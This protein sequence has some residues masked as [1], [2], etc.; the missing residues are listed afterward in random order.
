MPL[1]RPASRS[2]SGPATPFRALSLAQRDFIFLQV[3]Y[4]DIAAERRGFTE[5]ARAIIEQH[6]N[7]ANV[8][9]APDLL[10]PTQSRS[11]PPQ[12]VI[13]GLATGIY[14][15]MLL[16]DGIS[17]VQ[18]RFFEYQPPCD[19]GHPSWMD[20]HSSPALWRQTP[21][22]YARGQFH[23]VI[24]EQ[25]QRP[26]ATPPRDDVPRRLRHLSQ[27]KAE[28]VLDL[29]AYTTPRSAP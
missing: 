20:R 29:R 5:T 2:A 10:S 22:H 23:L 8:C 13:E 4:N 28:M 16:P 1:L 27:H 21:L 24:D 14:E 19:D 12:Y 25:T 15:Q 3:V 18:T 26:I 17:P 9:L 7:G 11:C 6:R